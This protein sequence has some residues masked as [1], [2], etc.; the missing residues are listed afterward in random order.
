[1]GVAA[2]VISNQWVSNQFRETISDY[3][4]TDY[5]LLVTSVATQCPI[6]HEDEPEHEDEYDFGRHAL[7]PDIVPR[8]TLA[9]GVTGVKDAA[10]F[11]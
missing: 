1:L 6:E 10:R 2:E 11:D 7:H 9:A 3:C 4:L 5:W 8:G